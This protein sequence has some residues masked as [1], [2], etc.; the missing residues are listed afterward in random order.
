MQIPDKCY[1]LARSI[2]YLPAEINNLTLYERKLVFPAVCRSIVLQENPYHNFGHNTLPEILRSIAGDD[3]SEEFYSQFDS[4]TT[5]SDYSNI[6]R[7]VVDGYEHYVNEVNH[8]PEQEIQ[9]VEVGHQRGYINDEM[10]FKTIR[11]AKAKKLPK[12]GFSSQCFQIRFLGIA[13]LYHAHLKLKAQKGIF[14]RPTPALQF[15]YEWMN[16]QGGKEASEYLDSLK[17]IA[18]PIADS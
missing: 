11:A 13:Q 4:L 8:E 5:Y 1:S 12:I 2:T 7:Q 9:A 3:R 16:S 15:W 17:Q 6:Y 14:T 18:H 10:Y